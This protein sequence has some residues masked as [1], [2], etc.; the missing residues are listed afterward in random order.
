MENRILAQAS[1]GLAHTPALTPSWVTSSSSI[2]SFSCPALQPSWLSSTSTTHPLLSSSSHLL[3]SAMFSS[4]L[5][6][7]ENTQL[8]QNILS[9]SLCS[10]PSTIPP[11]PPLYS[12]ALPAAVADPAQPEQLSVSPKKRKI[13]LDSLSSNDYTSSQI[14]ELNEVQAL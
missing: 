14:E 5:L 7:T 1:S 2:S 11:L 10:P 6:S 3:S 12:T 4:S 9:S 13:E 8:M